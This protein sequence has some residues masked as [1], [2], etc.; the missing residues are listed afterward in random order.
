MVPGKNL[1]FP[2]LRTP[3]WALFSAVCTSF[4]GTA[5]DSG[6]APE[7]LEL[8]PIPLLPPMC[9]PIPPQFQPCLK[10]LHLRKNQSYY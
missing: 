9:D 6:W 7:L 8:L 4:G 3:C 5:A 1:E 2:F 10:D